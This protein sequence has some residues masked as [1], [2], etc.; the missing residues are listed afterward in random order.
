MQEG[1]PRLVLQLIEA[2]LEFQM[3]LGNLNHLSIPEYEYEKC[4]KSEE[5]CTIIHG[6]QHN[7]KLT[8][9]IWKKSNKFQNSEKSEGS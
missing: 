1:A 4:Q 8:A 3:A 9:E 7:N 6:L 2:T 5:N